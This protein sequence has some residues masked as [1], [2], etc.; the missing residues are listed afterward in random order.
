MDSSSGFG[1]TA[2]A[3]TLP[4]P[5]LGNVVDRPS[6]LQVTKLVEEECSALDALLARGSDRQGSG[7]ARDRPRRLARVRNQRRYRGRRHP[8]IRVADAL[9]ILGAVRVAYAWLRAKT[10]KPV[11]ISDGMAALVAASALEGYKGSADMTV[12]HCTALHDQAEPWVTTGYLVGLFV[13]GS[14]FEVVV[15]KTGAMSTVFEVTMPDA[16]SESGP[17][18]LEAGALTHGTACRAGRGEHHWWRNRTRP[19][20]GAVLCGRIEVGPSEPAAP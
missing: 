15:S 7:T 2:T 8:G 12:D 13:G 20:A 5:K 10:G 9:A 6:A 3:P 1:S 14:L 19:R 17:T 18:D 16:H 11:A 4:P